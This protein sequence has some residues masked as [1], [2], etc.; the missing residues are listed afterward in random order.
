MK[1]ELA[2]LTRNKAI[3]MLATQPSMKIKDVAAEL[4]I[5]PKTI[6]AWNTDPNFI[7]AV[8]DRYMVAL[9]GELPSILNAMVREAK[10]GNVQAG[11]LLLEHSNKLVKNVNITIDSPFDKWLKKMDNAEVVEPE[12]MDGEVSDFEDLPPRDE[13]HPVV[14]TKRENKQIKQT[15][16]QDIKK[17]QQKKNR[18]K[19]R[20]EWYLWKKRALAVGLEAIAGN[21]PTKAQK[22]AYINKIKELESK[23]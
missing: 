20:K 18:S 9:G 23:E 3:D 19:K 13:E 16:Y 1:K 6:Y 14:R 15:Y 11:R 12:I 10:A 8:Y 21:R 5:S 7:D 17:D 2:L 22:E 4:G